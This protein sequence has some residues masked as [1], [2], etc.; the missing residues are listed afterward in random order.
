MNRLFLFSWTFSNISGRHT[1]ILPS[2]CKQM[3]Q[4]FKHNVVWGFLAKKRH[5]QTLLYSG[6]SGKIE[7]LR[8]YFNRI[9]ILYKC[10][11]WLFD[12]PHETLSNNDGKKFRFLFLTTLTL[13]Q[14]RILKNRSNLGAESILPSYF[15]PP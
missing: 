9:T 13:I 14:T 6:F 1:F 10:G 15:H 8:R 7:Y 11:T 3:L 5:N 12:L 4:P 2:S